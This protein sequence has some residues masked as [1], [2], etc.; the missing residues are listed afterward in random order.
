MTPKSPNLMTKQ[1]AEK[2][3]R[4]AE[5]LVSWWYRL[6]GYRVLERRFRC[7]YGE[8]D[9]IMRRGRQIVFIEVKFTT[10]ARQLDSVLPTPQQQQ[11]IRSAA[12]QFLAH[13][14][15]SDCSSRFDVVVVRPLF[16]VT[17]FRNVLM[18]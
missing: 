8:I 4:Q 14:N 12:T 10:A 15:Q 9:L 16:R 11:R 13:Q 6:A 3:G 1:R 5:V 7:R 18:G 17:C 2:K